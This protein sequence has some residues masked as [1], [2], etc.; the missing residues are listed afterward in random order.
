[1]ISPSPFSSTVTAV[2][3]DKLLGHMDSPTSRRG[4]A[5]RRS[6][7]GLRNSL[8][9]PQDETSDGEDDLESGPATRVASAVERRAAEAAL[10]T[11][12]VLPEA[13]G[14]EGKKSVRGRARSLSHTLGELF[15]VRRG[16]RILG[17]G[18]DAETEGLLGR[19][20]AGSE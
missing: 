13:S 11:D 1:M 18:S 16:R 10:F 4:I 12:D 8:F 14:A 9:V 7:P 17:E 5:T 2:V 20:G 15:G 19:D 6:R 3:A